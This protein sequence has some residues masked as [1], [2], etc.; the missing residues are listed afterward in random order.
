MSYDLMVFEKA[1][2]PT[3]R[4]E[5]MAW[6]EKQ[7]EWSEEHDYQTISVSSPALQKWFMEMIKKFPPM[8]GEYAPNLDPLDEN[9]AEDLERHMVDY[10]IGYDVIYAAFSWSVAEEAYELMRSLAQK[11]GVGFFDV[12]AD[13]GDIILPDGIM[14]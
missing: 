4:K 7:T 11:H 8:N 14:I 9:E 10:S 3:T 1:K 13:E 2:A 6:Y 5:F 12:S